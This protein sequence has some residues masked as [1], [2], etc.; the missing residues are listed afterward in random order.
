M[1]WLFPYRWC[2]WNHRH[3]GANA[4]D[5]DKLQCRVA[6]VLAGPQGVD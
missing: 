3:D 5:I 2:M 1:H 6:Q 4:L